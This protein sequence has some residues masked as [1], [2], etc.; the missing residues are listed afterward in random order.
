MNPASWLPLGGEQEFTQPSNHLLQYL[1]THHESLF[2]AIG[3]LGVGQGA[4]DAGM[5]AMVLRIAHASLEGN[6]GVR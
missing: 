4:R 1:C 5:V 6:R 3:I 2:A